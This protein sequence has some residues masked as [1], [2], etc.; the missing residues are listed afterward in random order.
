MS[1]TKALAASGGIIG[2][3]RL[4]PAAA[5]WPA[6]RLPSPS[7]DAPAGRRALSIG[8]KV[9][10]RPRRLVR[11]RWIADG[12]GSASRATGAGMRTFPRLILMGLA[13]PAAAL[14]RQADMLELVALGPGEG[15]RGFPC[16]VLI[17]LPSDRGAAAIVIPVKYWLGRPS[18]NQTSMLPESGMLRSACGMMRTRSVITPA[19]MQ[20]DRLA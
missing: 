2:P 17:H 16:L 14:A 13:D 4:R 20:S 18:A 15:S 3:V 10:R 7:P 9:F 11:C 19:M 8:L 12:A 1:R 6:R 5:G